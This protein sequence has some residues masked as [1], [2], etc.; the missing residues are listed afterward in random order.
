MPAEIQCLVMTRSSRYVSLKRNKWCARTTIVRAML[1]RSRAD[2]MPCAKPAC[3]A[4]ASAFSA[5]RLPAMHATA[6]AK[7]FFR[8][9]F[10]FLEAPRCPLLLDSC[11]RIESPQY[12]QSLRLFEI[13]QPLSRYA[14]SV[15]APMNPIPGILISLVTSS[16]T[17]AD[18]FRN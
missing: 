10:P 12:C 15:Q 16:L 4:L 18:T 2:S 8:Y 3:H 1:R 14:T 17:A 9:R 7:T 6:V 13:R 5:W 11:L